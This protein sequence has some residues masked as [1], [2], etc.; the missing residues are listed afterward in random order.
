M[1]WGRAAIAFM[2]TVVA[3]AG[4]ATLNKADAQYYFASIGL[5]SVLGL[6]AL[7]AV[8]AKGAADG[9]DKLYFGAIATLLASIAALVGGIGG[10]AVAG[11]EAGKTAA[12]EVATD[13]ARDTVKDTVKENA[14]KP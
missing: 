14:Q 10:G 11:D 7:L 4:L 3:L 5:L 1:T 13:T 9:Q 8:L 6:V 2:F 12:R